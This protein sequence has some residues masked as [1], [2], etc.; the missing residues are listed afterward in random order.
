[1]SRED[2]QKQ[3]RCGMHPRGAS[4]ILNRRCRAR[5]ISVAGRETGRFRRHGIDASHSPLT[6][7]R[8][9]VVDRTARKAGDWDELSYR[10]IAIYR[11]ELLTT[12]YAALASLRP[13]KIVGQRRR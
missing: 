3:P 8:T 4:V 2:R 6:C 1:M 5:P 12:C 13:V 10:L 11:R 7:S 9:R